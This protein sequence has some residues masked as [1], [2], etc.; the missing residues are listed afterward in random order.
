MPINNK[1]DFLKSLQGGKVIRFF[2]AGKHLQIAF[3]VLLTLASGL[4]EML[5]VAAIF[6]VLQFGVMKLDQ[7]API[8][9]QSFVSELFAKLV[10]F[11]G[12][13]PLIVSSLFLITIT[14]SSFFFKFFYDRYAQTV[15]MS[16]MNDMKS[17]LFA[18][19][20]KVDYM[21]FNAIHKADLVHTYVVFS[22]SISVVV[23]YIAR[24]AS[25][26]ITVILLLLLMFYS[27]SEY[28]LP[29][30]ILAGPI[31]YD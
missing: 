22:S 24:L 21:T 11:T 20:Q 17:K 29:I 15:A 19:Y 2:I 6:P 13:T 18:M 1:A 7:A 30:I 8:R 31:E 23:D 5:S 12:I 3:L 28:I 10:E 26:I 4:M 14:I 25:Q 16:V 27:A 9:N